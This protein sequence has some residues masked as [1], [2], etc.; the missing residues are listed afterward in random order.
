M[1]LEEI[2]NF[3]AVLNHDQILHNLYVGSHLNL[4]SAFWT[5][6]K[7]GYTAV[8]SLQTDADINKLRLNVKA[9]KKLYEWENVE[10][11][12]V[13][14]TDFSVADL[15]QKLPECV[16]ALKELID[17]GHIVYMHCNSGINRAPTVAVAYLFWE[18][19][20]PLDKAVEFVTS[21][22]PSNPFISAL[23]SGKMKYLCTYC[24]Q[25]QNKKGKCDACSQRV[26]PISKYFPIKKP[27][28][29]L[30]DKYAW[31]KK[32]PQEDT[33]RYDTWDDEDGWIKKLKRSYRQRSYETPTYE[34]DD[35]TSQ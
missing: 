7:T 10:F 30:W 4:S 24:G 5:Q 1:H 18:K 9:L 32:E 2:H 27:Q 6:E 14:V 26:T 17:A 29:Q 25:E 31:E 34:D 16:R 15:R 22:R 12:R 13:P 33:H 19:K 8:L 3:M 35:F 28:K 20:L 23:I 21:R 11:R